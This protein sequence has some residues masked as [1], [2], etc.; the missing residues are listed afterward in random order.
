MR[1]LLPWR[2]SQSKA[3]AWMD[4]SRGFYKEQPTELSWQYAHLHEHEREK[5][6]NKKRKGFQIQSMG[7]GGGQNA[8]KL[9]KK[10]FVK[11]TWTW[12]AW[13]CIYVRINHCREGTCATLVYIF[14]K[15][16]SIEEE[17]GNSQSVNKKERERERGGVVC[18]GSV[19]VIKGRF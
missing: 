4:K 14:K 1:D 5:H 6:K 9:C 16:R 3:W 13:P 7:N 15:W 19:D 10:H 8:N 11:P 2:L 12:K 18:G 17:E